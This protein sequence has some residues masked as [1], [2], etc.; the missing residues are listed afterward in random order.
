MFIDKFQT[1]HINFKFELLKVDVE[2]LFEIPKLKRVEF[3]DPNGIDTQL[4]C[5]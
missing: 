2:V 5:S 4:L 1:K 3:L